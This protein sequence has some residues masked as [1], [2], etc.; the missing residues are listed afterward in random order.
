MA[1]A[2][3][4]Y[5]NLLKQAQEDVWRLLSESSTIR[6]YT[7][8][9]LSNFPSS[10]LT[11]NLGWPFIV[12]PIPS[13]DEEQLTMGQKRIF[14]LFNIEV[15]FKKLDSLVLVDAIRNL[16]STNKGTFSG[17]YNL[18]QFLAGGG[19][20]VIELP[21]GSSANQ[22]VLSVEYEWIGDPS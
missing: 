6:G 4:T 5:S 9:I 11:K 18:N 20:S 10:C 19:V 15:W 2:E 1:Y 17:T 22:Y 12:V 16:L 3:V 14:L 13:M 7:T 21:D 8:T